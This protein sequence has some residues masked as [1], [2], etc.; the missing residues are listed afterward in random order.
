MLS[1]IQQGGGG[2]PMM[3][4]TIKRHEVDRVLNTQ[5]EIVQEARQIR[6]VWCFSFFPA[7]VHFFLIFCI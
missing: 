3:I 6:L 2:Q 7:Q 4:D 1:F 5:N